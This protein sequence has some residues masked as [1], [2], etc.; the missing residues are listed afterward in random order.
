VKQEANMT[1]AN[2]G[3][4]GNKDV[5]AN[6]EQNTPSTDAMQPTSTP[7]V[8]GSTDN[9]PQA[10]AQGTTPETITVTLTGKETGQYVGPA[11]KSLREM[12]A[13]KPLDKLQV[14][15]AADGDKAGRM[16][17]MT[18]PVLASMTLNTVER[19]TLG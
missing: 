2:E 19:A 17:A 18:T 5:P 4:G 8:A 10:V 7:A 11:G 9:A 15:H 12:F 3:N 1:N 13:D 16:A 14:R 6:G